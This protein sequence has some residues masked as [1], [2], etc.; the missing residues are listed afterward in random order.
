MHTNLLRSE[1]SPEMS[2]DESHYDDNKV[3]SEL[4]PLGLHLTTRYT[5]TLVRGT[6]TLSALCNPF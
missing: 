3:K 5:S 2:E 4:S 6:W 1:E